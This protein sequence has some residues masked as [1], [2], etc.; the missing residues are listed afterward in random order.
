MDQTDFKN[1][2]REAEK[3][4]TF[5][6]AL[7]LPVAEPEDD[8]K[9]ETE[10]FSELLLDFKSNIK[11][12]NEINKKII[13]LQR[14]IL[15]DNQYIQDDL[16]SPRVSGFRQNR[17]LSNFNSLKRSLGDQRIFLEDRGNVIKK[18]LRDLLSYSKSKDQMKMVADC[19][20]DSHDEILVQ[21]LQNEHIKEIIRRNLEKK[22]NNSVQNISD[23]P[24]VSSGQI[25]L[26]QEPDIIE[27]NKNDA[28]LNVEKK[29]L[30]EDFTAFT[31]DNQDKEKDEFLRIDKLD[32]LSV[33]T[34]LDPNFDYS[35]Q[36][37]VKAADKA[38][39]ADLLNNDSQGKLNPIE[40]IKTPSLVAAKREPIKEPVPAEP[41][42]TAE[43]I[44]KSP[45]TMIK[46]LPNGEYEDL[47]GDTNTISSIDNL[48]Q[49][50][51]ANNISQ[52]VEA[53]NGATE[54]TAVSNSFASRL[55][56]IKARVLDNNKL[57]EE[58]NTAKVTAN[59][60][61]ARNPVAPKA[62]VAPEPMADLSVNNND[63]SNINPIIAPVEQSTIENKPLEPAPAQP[64]SAETKTPE[65]S[66]PE[67][68]ISN[69]EV[70][71]QAP[72]SAPQTQQPIPAT[73]VPTMESLATREPVVPNTEP[74]P[75]KDISKASKIFNAFMGLTK[76]KSNKLDSAKVAAAEKA[77]IAE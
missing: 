3:F 73:T 72:I 18:E 27:T 43:N 1:N 55:S 49:S 2:S 16:E 6:D 53:D 20:L 56:E 75:A 70:L 8:S 36:D 77:R 29:D 50:E 24:I 34:A 23:E 17:A 61:F 15:E 38:A 30:H 33:P 58:N 68:I 35:N 60:F 4:E 46:F 40:G 10:S 9:P 52:P 19:I 65:I 7:G 37:G 59:D 41:E 28:D 5:E 57:P 31:E 12:H 22:T 25:R 74:K 66:Q 21:Y 54:N 64:L 26:D 45:V 51:M 76:L 13:D 44:F 11:E 39:S 62:P 71:P 47:G 48:K 42:P 69:Q 63:Q 67:T 14:Q 32:G